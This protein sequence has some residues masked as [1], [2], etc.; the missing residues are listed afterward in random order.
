MIRVETHARRTIIKVPKQLFA[1][2]PQ[3]FY[4]LAVL[5]SVV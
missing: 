3:E 1:S 4:R 2:P 5:K